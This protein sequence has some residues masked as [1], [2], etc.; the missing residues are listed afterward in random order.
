MK[1]SDRPTYP[2]EYR[3]YAVSATP[4]QTRNMFHE[5]IASTASL[6]GGPGTLS[7]NQFNDVLDRVLA[8]HYMILARKTEI[9]QKQMPGTYSP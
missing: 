7:D 5:A 4:R 1:P 9:D 3:T 6:H 2:A 8:C